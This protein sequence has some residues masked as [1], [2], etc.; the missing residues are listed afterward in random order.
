VIPG[1]T[2]AF[3]IILDTEKLRNSEYVENETG[4][5]TTFILLDKELLFEDIIKNGFNDHNLFIPI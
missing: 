1:G 3:D 5:R 2:G 4:G